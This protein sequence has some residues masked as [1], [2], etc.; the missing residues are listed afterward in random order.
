MCVCCKSGRET[1]RHFQ[2]RFGRRWAKIDGVLSPEHA[3]WIVGETDGPLTLK[4]VERLTPGAARILAR[5]RHDIRLPSVGK[6]DAEVAGLLSR[7]RHRLF[8]DGCRSLDAEAAKA[9][10]VHGLAKMKRSCKVHEVW[11]HGDNGSFPYDA[12]LEEE[13]ELLA[14][15]DLLLGMGPDSQTLSL[16]G[17][18]ELPPSVARGLGTHRG[19][20]VLD[21]LQE[22]SDTS[23][24][25]LGNHFGTLALNSLRRLSPRAA[26]GLAYGGGAWPEYLGLEGG[27]EL[28]GLKS[29][30][31]EAARALA[32]HQGSL[33]LNG[34]K[35]LTPEVAEALSGFRP[36]KQH[37]VL[38]LDGVRRLSPE[39]ARGLAPIRARIRFGR[40][41]TISPLLAEALAETHCQLEL[42][43]VR[44]LSSDAA[45]NLLSKLDVS[46]LKKPC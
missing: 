13:V 37:D 35:T 30:S 28:D 25:E 2:T 22:L 14:T 42:P 9:L 3:A 16:S 23:A 15:D 18:Q 7:H 33:S 38:I 45:A 1:L 27:L 29:I 46:L 41:T 20:L 21:G 31:P 34:L 43:M 6:L 26:Q 19:T 24:E 10:A 8:L 40:L 39:A 17:L 36:L 44:R 32:T 11:F 12:A 5:H 4:S